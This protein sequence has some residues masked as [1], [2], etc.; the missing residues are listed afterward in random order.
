MIYVQITNLN[1]NEIVYKEYCG[2]SD[3]PPTCT[4]PPG[5]FS[6]EFIDLYYA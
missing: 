3:T 4:L 6:I 1:T 2:R 5:N